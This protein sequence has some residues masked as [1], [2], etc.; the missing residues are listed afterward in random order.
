MQTVNRHVLSTIKAF[1]A[2]DKTSLEDIAQHCVMRNFA[3]GE[4]IISYQE[5]S[6]TVFFLVSGS[7]KATMFTPQGR[8]ISYQELQPGEMFGELAALDHMPRSTSVI[9]IGDV[10][11]ISVGGEAFMQILS[12][13]PGIAQQTLKKMAGV[14]RFLCDRVYNYGALDVNNRIRQE[15]CRLAAD[16]GEV[17]D[18]QPEAIVISSMPKQ[19]EL[20]NR[21]ATH[22][23]AVSR[24]LRS[25]EKAGIIEKR[26]GQI[27]IYDLKRLEQL[28]NN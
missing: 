25:L 28:V 26:K 12:S 7:V 20:A 5:L 9:A 1:Q 8:E 22:R 6:T 16:Y 10:S 11:L 18:G 21:L 15:L 23:E 2:L 24:E 17:E 14:I 27:V 4:T 13:Y 3:A 19:Q